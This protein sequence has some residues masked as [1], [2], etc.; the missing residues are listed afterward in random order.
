MSAHEDDVPRSD[1]VP[2]SPDRMLALLEQQQRQVAAR[3]AAFVPWILAAW[4]VAWLAGFLIL[5]ADALQHPDDW[6]PSI[7]ACLAFAGLLAA[8]GVLSAVLGIRSARGLRGTKQ[9]TIVGIVYGNTWWIGGIALIVIGRSLH[10][11]GMREELLAVFYPSAFILFS[12]I[13]CLMGGL[14]WHAA[15]MM[16]LGVWCI[17]LSAAG[18]MLPPPSNHLAY[19]LA[20]GGAFLLVAGWSAWWVHSSRRRPAPAGD[21]RG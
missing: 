20:G 1:D 11:F 6:R 5:Q 8:A 10:G 15:P 14:I 7:A 3:T 9:G 18:A 19:A 12:G 16:V 2:L 13:M 4:G 21:A 17:I